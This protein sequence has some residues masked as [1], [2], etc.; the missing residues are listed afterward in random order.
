LIRG[1]TSDAEAW[2][3]VWIIS[4]AFESNKRS[5]FFVVKFAI[6]SFVEL[7]EQRKGVVLN[8]RAA[9]CLQSFFELWELDSAVA[10]EIEVLEV[11]AGSFSLVVRAVSALSDLLKQNVLKLSGISQIIA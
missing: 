11:L 4:R 8:K 3:N 2:I 10:I 7:E 9:Q 6:A 5:E 1:L